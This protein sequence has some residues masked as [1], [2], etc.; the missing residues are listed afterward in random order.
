MDMSARRLMSNESVV[1]A[2]LGNEAVLLNVHS[3]V[4]FGLDAVGTRIWQLLKQGSTEEALVDQLFKEYAVDRAQL[5]ADIRGFVQ[6]LAAKGL[7]Q[8][9]AG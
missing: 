6:A 2:V 4:Y 5:R 8:E 9:L 1:E 7:A 3:G